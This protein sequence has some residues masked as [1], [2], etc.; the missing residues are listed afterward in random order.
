[1]ETKKL[2]ENISKSDTYQYAIFS[3]AFFGAMVSQEERIIN[4]IGE[5]W[6]DIIQIVAIVMNGYAI[7]WNRDR[8]TKPL[9]EV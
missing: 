1:M 2:I 8:T 4:L 9:D 7:K 3:I 5:K 6:N